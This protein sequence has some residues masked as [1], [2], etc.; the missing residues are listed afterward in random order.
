M[1]LLMQ[2][3]VSSRI[4]YKDISSED[5]S[6]FG[7]T[8][9]YVYEP[10]ITD[11][12]SDASV[13][14]NPRTNTIKHDVLSMNVDGYDCEQFVAEYSPVSLYSSKRSSN[15]GVVSTA[16]MYVQ[17]FA[18][19]LPF[20]VENLYVESRTNLTFNNF[21][22]WPSVYFAKGGTVQLEGNFNDFFRV[23]T[24]LKNQELN[25]F[26]IL[27]P[28]VMMH[29]LTTAGNFD[30]EFSGNTVYF[31]KSFAASAEKY[32]PMTRQDFEV[33]HEFGVESAKAM[34]RA[35]RPS[36]LVNPADY[37]PMWTLYGVSILT[38]M[39]YLLAIWAFMGLFVISL[40]FP[41]LFALILILAIRKWLKLRRL[42]SELKEFANY[43]RRNPTPNVPDSSIIKS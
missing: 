21:I 36:K 41:P 26:L 39:L 33:L 27:A 19:K 2:K 25:A 30:F 13:Y 35:G 22:G 4:N 37:V 6:Q 12:A 32:A 11:T 24:P 28:N 42:R 29:M 31:Y 18:V 7:A 5:I 14:I 15:A 34:V 16:R 43:D 38:F 3:L 9:G 17:V 40:A 20:V 8:R 1:I 23:H 10:S